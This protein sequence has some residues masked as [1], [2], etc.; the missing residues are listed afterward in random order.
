MS[1]GKQNVLKKGPRYLVSSSLSV[2]VRVLILRRPNVQG[3]VSPIGILLLSVLARRQRTPTSPSCV[4]YIRALQ[5]R[6]SASASESNLPSPPVFLD[7]AYFILYGTY[8]LQSVAASLFKLHPPYP[9]SSPQMSSPPYA[10]TRSVPSLMQWCLIAPPRRHT[11]SRSS[12]TL[13]YFKPPT[14]VHPSKAQEWDGMLRPARHQVPHY[15]SEAAA[16]VNGPR[17]MMATLL[18]CF[19]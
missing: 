10:S 9:P 15:T 3:S 11:E 12:Y 16:T 1:S 7:H 2:C 17:M 6:C 8:T 4:S 13:R 19:E 14:L 5:Q 18:P